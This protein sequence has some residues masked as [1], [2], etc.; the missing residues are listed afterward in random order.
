MQVAAHDIDE[1]DH[2][3]LRYSIFVE[4]Q[5]TS[6][7]PNGS[8]LTYHQDHRRGTQ[9]KNHQLMQQNTSSTEYFAIDPKTGDIQFIKVR[10]CYVIH[11]E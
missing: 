6:L 4:E 8:S 9:P 11:K 3:S 7:L 5:D 2:D 10:L 1:S